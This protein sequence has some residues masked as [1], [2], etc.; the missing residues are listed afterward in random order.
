[1]ARRVQIDPVTRIE[2]H[3][4]VEAHFEGHEVRDATTSSQM[5]R[6]IEAA[7]TGYDPRAALQVT[8][9]VCGVCPYAHAEASAKAIEQAMQIT[10]PPNGV[11]LRNMIVGAYQL[12]DYLLHF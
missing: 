10:P 11:A 9:R 1:M 5:F 8:Q 12:H 3:L 4:K 7:L 2:G 6:G